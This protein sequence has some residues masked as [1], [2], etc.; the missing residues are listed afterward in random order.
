MFIILTTAT[1]FLGAL[2]NS[3]ANNSKNKFRKEFFMNAYYGLTI[4]GLIA[5]FTTIC[6]YL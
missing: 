4:V 6:L 3:V 5:S 1:I 2:C